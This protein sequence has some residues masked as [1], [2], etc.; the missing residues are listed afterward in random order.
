MAKLPPEVSL[1]YCANAFRIE[2]CEDVFRFF[3]N[4]AAWIAASYPS[5]GVGLW[6]SNQVVTELIAARL[7]EELKEKVLASR[8]QVFSMNGFP[9]GNFHEARIKGSVYSPNWSELRRFDYTLQLIRV[10]QVL[11]QKG[12]E[13]CISTLPL[14]DRWSLRHPHLLN[15]T[16][17]FLV[18]IADVLD[19][20]ERDT[21]VRINLAL[22]PEPFCYLETA[23]DVVRYFQDFLLMRGIPE[24][25]ARRGMS[26][27]SAHE[28]ILD[29]IRVCHDT[30]HAAVLFQEPVDVIKT[31]QKF[32]IQIGKVQVSSALAFECENGKLKSGKSIVECMKPFAEDRYLHQ[33]VGWDHAGRRV[34]FPDLSEAIAT[35]EVLP[36]SGEFRCHYHVPIHCPDFGE[37]GS[38]QP[39]LLKFL[40]LAEGDSLTSHWEIETYTW[41]VLPESIQEESV[42]KGIVREVNWILS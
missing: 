4:E 14:G 42:A 34:E 9:W 8:L 27:E 2:S 10:A 16:A 24:L 25:K 36:P 13:F 3:R 6:L 39:D 35:W 31:Y 17:T 29:R 18:Q 30:C 33:V 7:I 37:I 11:A 22:E 21:G 41:G 40:S 19:R 23:T 1:G 26:S 15:Q 20:L 32:G 5:L 38:T 28:M 12:R